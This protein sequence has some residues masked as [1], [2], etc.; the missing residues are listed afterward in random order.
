MNTKVAERSS[1]K[2][3]ENGN[4][5]STH[6][7]WLDS[8]QSLGSPT[9]GSHPEDVKRLLK[10]FSESYEDFV[11]FAILRS[12]STAVAEDMVQQAFAN[13]L[14]TLER[15]NDIDNM[16]A[17]LQRC[18]SNLCINRSRRVE[19][20]SVASESYRGIASTRT[21]EDTAELRVDWETVSDAIDGLTSMQRKAFVMAE[22]IGAE[23]REIAEH[24]DRSIGS[25]RQLVSRARCQ[26]RRKT[27]QGLGRVAGWI[28][29]SGGDSFLARRRDTSAKLRGSAGLATS[30]QILAG[31][32]VALAAVGFAAVNLSGLDTGT[33]GD[34][35]YGDMAHSRQVAASPAGHRV[36]LATHRA[37]RL[38]GLAGNGNERRGAKVST[39]G[40]VPEQIE[41]PDVPGP[42][43]P[44]GKERTGG[45]SDD[46]EF[47]SHRGAVVH[48][49]ASGDREGSHATV[50]ME[51]AD[52]SLAPPSH[53]SP[54]RRYA[55]QQWIPMGT[56]W[57]TVPEAAWIPMGT[58]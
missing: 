16:T 49:D 14:V 17:F 19:S 9:L 51:S 13:T 11:R 46:D 24:L 31:N 35:G 28:P 23:H 7:P 2:S 1:V 36:Q 18:I 48:A 45:S 21:T 53:S 5:G 4:G 6:R 25:V 40:R 41:A 55:R 27:R 34:T 57:L 32:A 50:P 12:G 58:A 39:V 15:G 20:E 30:L 22:L 37:V 29:F 26:I 10:V 42:D 38:E 54:T 3:S 44:D 8:E 56:A 43:G 47:A 33:P 52:T